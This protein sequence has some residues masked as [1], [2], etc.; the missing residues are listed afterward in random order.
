MDCVSYTAAFRT[1]GPVLPCSTDLGYA[2]HYDPT[3]RAVLSSAML[4]RHAGRGYAQD[5]HALQRR[6]RKRTTPYR[7]TPFLC[8]NHLS[9][10]ALPTPCPVLA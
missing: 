8:H 6:L 1:V 9:P 3:R 10:Y 7:P 4:L 5:L 2:V